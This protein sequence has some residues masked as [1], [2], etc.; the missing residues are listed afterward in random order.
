MDAARAAAQFVP[1]L[2]DNGVR[3]EDIAD[4]IGHAGTTVTGKV[5]RH[6]LQPVLLTGS[7]IVG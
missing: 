7:S 5:Y 4:L 1:V 3:L 6:Q 2:S